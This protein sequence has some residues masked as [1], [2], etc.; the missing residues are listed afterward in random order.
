MRHSRR[1]YVIPLIA[2]LAVVL[3]AAGVAFALARVGSAPTAIR[4]VAD[5]APLP[6]KPLGAADGTTTLDASATIATVASV[7]VEVEVPDVV[8]K[9]VAEA[10]AI[11]DAAGFT[12]LTRVADAAVP[13]L[14]PDSVVSQSPHAG[15]RLSPGGRVVLTYQPASATPAGGKQFVVVIDAGHQAKADVTLEPIG[16]GSPTRKPKVAGGATTVTKYRTPEYKL[17]LAVALKLRDRLQAQG[18]KVVMIRTTNEVNIA[19]SKRATIG[20]DA[21]ADLVVR[22]H[23]DGA[24]SEKAN[25]ISTLFPSGNAWCKP[26]EAPSKAAATIVENAV[27]KATGAKKNGIVGRGDMTGFNWSTRPTIIVECGFLSNPTEAARC[28]TPAYQ[29]R[30]AS[31]LSTGVTEYLRGR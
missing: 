16:P 19:N 8:S 21:V 11:I 4:S 6:D 31:G 2:V 24:I 13:G 17:T 20:N 7:P 23:F 12:T 15:A 10:E 26:I 3:V 18:I 9:P 28:E 14:A 5:D 30:I 22:V 27:T 1:A 29:D 25:G